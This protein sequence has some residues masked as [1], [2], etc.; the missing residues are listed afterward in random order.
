MHFICVNIALLVT[1]CNY[2]RRRSRRMVRDLKDNNDYL[3]CLLS[4]PNLLRPCPSSVCSSISG[5][6]PPGGRQC[7][8]SPLLPRNRELRPGLPWTPRTV[9]SPA[10]PPQKLPCQS[11]PASGQSFAASWLCWWPSPASGW[12]PAPGGGW[13]P[14]S[15]CCSDQNVDNIMT[16]IR[17]FWWRQQQQL[18]T[19]LHSTVNKF[20]MGAYIR[21]ETSPDWQLWS[22][23][24]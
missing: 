5:W 18:M 9:A 19:N 20:S 6:E 1:I 12:S 13:W 14:L 16:D 2:W 7:P 24:G 22:N 3:R 11:S 15:W 21:G 17:Q 4:V 23:N 10:Q 8:W